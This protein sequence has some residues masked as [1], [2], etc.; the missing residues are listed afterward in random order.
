MTE[1]DYQLSSEI[2]RTTQNVT[3][4]KNEKGIVEI[5]ADVPAV[6]IRFDEEPCG[7][8][9]RGKGRLRV[10]T[11]AETEQGA[12]GKPVDKEISEPFLMLG[13]TEGIQESLKLVDDEDLA[14]LEIETSQ[15]FVTEA[16]DLLEKF[17]QRSSHGH[18]RRFKNE[19]EGFIFAFQNEKGKL[20]LLIGKDTKL[21]YTAADK[22]FVS[23]RN[24]VV[25]TSDGEVVISRPGKSVVVSKG[26]HGSIH[27][28]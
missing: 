2:F 9:F 15:D 13:K 18:R 1:T 23:K 22:V 4:W 21:V 25:L 27:I 28:H 8:I 14:R 6:Q 5:A 11:I 10:D 20:D 3:L 19:L 12:V 7:Y 24:K 26:C 16:E 17:L